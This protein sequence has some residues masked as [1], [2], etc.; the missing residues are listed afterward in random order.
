M[1]P[2]G[3]TRGD[4]VSRFQRFG[5]GVAIAF[6]LVSI[7]Y[8]LLAGKSS[9][10]LDQ[11][12][13][14]ITFAHWGLED[15]YREGVAEAIRRFEELKAREGEKVRVIQLAVPSRGYSQWF[16]TQ[17]I[18]GNPADLIKLIDRN[19]HLYN[20]YF[21]AL[22]PYVDQPNPF[23]KGT[24][25]EGVPWRD[26]YINNMENSLDSVYSEYYGVGNTF[27]VYRLFV[28]VDLLEKA[29]GSRQLPRDLS[30]WLDDCAKLKEYGREIG[31]PIIPIGV[32]GFDKDTLRWLFQYYFSQMTG[33]LND[34]AS[35]FGGNASV[36]DVLESMMEDPRVRERICAVVDVVKELGMNFG[37]GF[38]A[39]DVEQTKF[40]F[41]SGLT[42][43]FPEG[44]WNAWSMVNN[45]P[46]EVGIIP[47]P[48][49]EHKHRHSKHFTGRITESSRSV[50]GKM[51][52]TKTTKH[53]DL[54]LEFLQFYTSYEI[55]QLTMMEYP[56]WPPAVRKARYKGILK[57]FQ[58][59]IRDGNQHVN[60]PFG[61][62]ARNLPSHRKH[63]AC[64]EEIITKDIAN[65]GEYYLDAFKANKSIVL[66]EG[67]EYVKTYYRS[68]L[69]NE[70][71]RSQINI[72]LL[73]SDATPREVERLRTRRTIDS[74]SHTGNISGHLKMLHY[75]EVV[76]GM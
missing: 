69:D 9:G 15:G 1:A 72:G 33:N 44:T 42:G 50:G 37:E 14:T 75:Y 34:D 2:A 68:Q 54:V 21:V 45:S 73:R 46:F 59:E 24:V 61:V 64:L 49:L 65:P 7:G 57:S 32:R 67:A 36:A 20:R 48:L 70:M 27:H 41:Y 10:L 31:A 51:G 25:L 26:T 40:L 62:G 22:T 60:V 28:N 39:M 30:E 13:K 66:E 16:L 3:S 4:D 6:Y 23:N 12:V 17:L 53:F 8:V 47:F 63:L 74:V 35:T 5:I 76:R 11:D 19:R 29:T 52:I 38:T 55:N 71:R 18:G 58:L 56:R 43:F